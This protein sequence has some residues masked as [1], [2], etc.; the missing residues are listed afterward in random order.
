MT[1]DEVLRISQGLLTPVIAAVATY[2]AWQQWRTNQ[3]KLKLDRYERRL[4]VYKEVVRFISVGIR[5]A[6]YDDN[7]LMTFRS[8]VSEADFLFGEEVPKYIDELHGR[9][10]N[11]YTW[12][13]EYRDYSQPKPE[14]YDHAKVVE[15]MHHELKWVSSQ[16]D[17][18]RKIF[19]K[20]LDV[21]R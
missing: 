16:L 15:G 12:T 4:Q 7:E 2:I 3:N 8:K 10:V 17:P 5:D 21:S 18:A 6:T 1:I 9:A 13:K 14:G 19:K 20:Y 11:L